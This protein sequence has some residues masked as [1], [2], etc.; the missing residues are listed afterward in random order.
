MDTSWNYFICNIFF[1]YMGHEFLYISL[2]VN[3]DIVPK[4]THNTA[5]ALYGCSDFTGAF[6]GQTFVTYVFA[7]HGMIAMAPV[8]LCVE[9]ISVTCL[10]AMTYI[11]NKRKKKEIIKKIAAGML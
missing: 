4:K 7:K 1:F 11:L 10:I 9:L 5:V 6:I 2:M 8:M 3:I